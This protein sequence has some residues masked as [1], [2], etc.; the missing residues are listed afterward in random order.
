[1]ISAH[2]RVIVGRVRRTVFPVRRV[3]GAVQ[4]SI[5]PLEEDGHRL[6]VPV[7]AEVAGLLTN[8]G[9]NDEAKHACTPRSPWPSGR[10]PRPP[11]PPPNPGATSTTH[12]GHR[13]LSLTLPGPL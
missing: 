3:R 8:G 1:M 6:I 13:S 9:E 7:L 11:R 4:P 12:R 10:P 2:R 5:E